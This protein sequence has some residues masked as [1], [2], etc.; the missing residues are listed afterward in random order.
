IIAARPSVGKS[1]FVANIAEN[2][3]VREGKSVAFFSL[4]MSEIELAQ[5]F[6]A[7]QSGV[8]GDRLRKGRIST[9]DKSRDWR[10][11]IEACNRLDQAPLFID[12]TSDLG[13]LDLRAKARRLH[14]QEEKRNGVGLSMI[15]VDYLQ[16]MRMD[17]S[18]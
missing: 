1:A 12:V 10:K 3:A 7:S 8:H 15:I 2:V 16:L 14:A 11:M 13:L 17:E 5:R 4:E 9:D 6:I 18:K